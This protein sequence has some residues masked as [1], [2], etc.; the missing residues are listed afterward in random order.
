MGYD[1]MSRLLHWVTAL[2]VFAMIPA[3]LVMSEVDSKPVQDTLFLFHK[4]GGAVLILLLAFRLIWR[5]THRAPPLPDSLPAIQKLAAH[6]THVA[7]YFILIVMALSGYVR[8]R[9]G[10]FPVELLDA[11]G[12]PSMIPRDDA[13][14]ATA[15][16]IHANA[17]FALGLL[18]ALHVGAAAYHGLIRKDGVFSRMWPS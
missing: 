10:G 18:I 12:V 14:A 5:A 11:I 1:R 13:L 2:M 8:V 7:L 15:K 16:A 9:A 6:A 17:K 3:G 4:N